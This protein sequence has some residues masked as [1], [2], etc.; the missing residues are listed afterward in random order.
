MTFEQIFEGR[1]TLMRAQR[2]IAQAHVSR[3]DQSGNTMRPIFGSTEGSEAFWL[4]EGRIQALEIE[5]TEK[6]KSCNRAKRQKLDRRADQ[7][8]LRA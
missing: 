5:F 8:V 4:V 7:Q 1:L 2:H 6:R 3:Y